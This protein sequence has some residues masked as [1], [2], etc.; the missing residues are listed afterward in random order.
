MRFGASTHLASGDAH[1]LHLFAA[2]DDHPVGEIVGRQRHGDS[3]SE[4]DS[5]AIFAHAAT[6]LGPHVRASVGL[7]IELTTGKYIDDDTFQLHMIVTAHIF[8][9]NP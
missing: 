7:H 3:I 9:A 6:K 8:S 1:A 2:V 4:N 5:D